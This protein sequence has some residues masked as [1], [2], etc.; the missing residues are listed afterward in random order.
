MT[1]LRSEPG[2]KTPRDDWH[3]RHERGQR[4]RRAGSQ[5]RQLDKGLPNLPGSFHQVDS[6]GPRRWRVRSSPKT[7]SGTP[8][9]ALT[10]NERRSVRLRSGTEAGMTLIV[11]GLLLE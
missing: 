2:E 9:D 8:N 3:E 10:L 6:R 5:S 1:G 4:T 7:L 11:H